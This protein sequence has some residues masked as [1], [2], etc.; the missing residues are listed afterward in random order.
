MFSKVK[1]LRKWKYLY[2]SN[3]FYSK[4]Y[5]KFLQG[6]AKADRFSSIAAWFN[7]QAT[8]SKLI[9]FDLEDLFCVIYCAFC[10]ATGFGFLF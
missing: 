10:T 5:F 4:P 3:P 1:C 7:K 6:I 2:I 8:R 9:N